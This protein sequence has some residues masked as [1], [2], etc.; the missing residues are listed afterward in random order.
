MFQALESHD[1]GC[2]V[3]SGR[4]GADVFKVYSL[5]YIFRFLVQ[6]KSIKNQIAIS[7]GVFRSLKNNN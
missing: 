2:G 5:Y 1:L 6:F 4:N 3:G 7:K